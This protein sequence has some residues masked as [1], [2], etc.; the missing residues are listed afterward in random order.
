[1]S[2]AYPSDGGVSVAV[3]GMAGRFPG[4]GEV[5]DFWR[6]LVA[7]DEL[8]TRFPEAGDGQ[9]TP[10]YGITPD[11]DWFDADFFGYSPAE[12]LLIDPQQRIFLECC[13]EALERAGYD[14]ARYR[15]AIGVY[16][17]SGASDYARQLRA[18]PAV[19]GS[20]PDWHLQL[21]TAVDFLTTR[22]SYKLGLTGPAITVQTACSTSL[23]AVHLAVQAVLAGECD[24]ALAGGVNVCTPYPVTLPPEGG[25]FSSDGYCRP[26]DARAQGTV[27]ADGS[28][29]VVL[30]QLAD[31]LTDGDHVHAVIRGSAVNNDGAGKIGFTAPSV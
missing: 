26:F 24:L 3:I 30:K 25:I 29:V 7:G 8:I 17:G 2:D 18:D 21:A 23:V 4:T 27:G 10:A 28:G 15:G 20:V 5:D 31:A 11:A 22:A 13:W 12:A 6:H 14:P 16:G 9:R 19:G 1:M